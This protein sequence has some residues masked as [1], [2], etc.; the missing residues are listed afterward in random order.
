MTLASDECTK[1]SLASLMVLRS[2]TMII[3]VR[4]LVVRLNFR[5]QDKTVKNRE[6]L[7]I[8]KDHSTQASLKS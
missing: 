6:S 3:W 2:K 4:R 7:F 8:I 1:K 5:Q